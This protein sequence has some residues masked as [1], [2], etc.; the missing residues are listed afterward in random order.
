ML[1]PRWRKVLRDVWL[2]KS[3]TSLVVAAIVVGIV[4]AGS[5]LNAWALVE[6]AT[7]DGYRASNPPSATIRTDSVDDALLA[8]VLAIPSV[9]DA[10]AR[11]TVA[12]SIQGGGTWLP[13]L[14]FVTD[15]FTAIRIGALHPEVGAWPP[16]DGAI[17]IER[18]SLDFS[19]ASVGESLKVAIGD[20]SPS[21]LQVTGVA[22]DVGLAPG[23][24]KSV[25]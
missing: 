25:V 17:V 3:R 18:S 5:I 14:L 19:A 24:R 10:Q 11:R 13:A 16:L 22:R 1:S 23:D 15:D 9:R 6:V 7:R 4:G 8:R 2:H 21:A 20:R 12:A